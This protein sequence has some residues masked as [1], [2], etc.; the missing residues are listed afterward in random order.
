MNPQHLLTDPNQFLY[1]FNFET[2]KVYFVKI[3][4]E[5]YETKLS[6]ASSYSLELLFSLLASENRANPR[7]KTAPVSHYI[8]MTDFC[9]ST[10]LANALGCLE[11]IF[12]CEERLALSQLGTEK[13]RQLP[14]A[15]GKVMADLQVD[16]YQLQALVL[17][18][19]SK[20]ASLGQAALFK[21][22]GAA[23]F[24]VPEQLNADGRSRAIFMYSTLEE[25]LT[26]SLKY[27]SRRK[28]ARGRVEESFTALE[29]LEPLHGIERSGLRDHEVCALHWLAL[30]YRYTTAEYSSLTGLLALQSRDFFDQPRET[31]ARVAA[32]FGIHT[33]AGELERI[34]NGPVFSRYSKDG[35]VA[36]SMADRDSA[37]KEAQTRFQ[38]EIAAGLRFAEQ[39]TAR[40][41]LPNCLPTDLFSADC[42]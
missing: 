5:Q 17:R 31:I 3:V 25:Y 8:F 41:P 11:G 1:S 13:Y 20:T 2:G 16:W 6:K 18:Y 10:L 26:A 36:F 32:H 9:G 7:P 39:I 37:N 29:L 27:K 34:I 28:L 12:W 30:M 23:N 4:R 42:Q 22:W 38:E 35:A 14:S 21:E 40:H 33:R 24:I 19:Q 15:A